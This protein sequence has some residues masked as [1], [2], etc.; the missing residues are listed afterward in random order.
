MEHVA[1][2]ND[3]DAIIFHGDV[4]LHQVHGLAYAA[5]QYTQSAAAETSSSLLLFTRSLT[6]R[7]CRLARAQ[8]SYC[9]L[10]CFREILI[11][12]LE[13]MLAPILPA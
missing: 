10:C 2:S 4:A 6:D 13:V 11:Q 8:S 3:D 1:V 9:C 12:E 7:K 5:R